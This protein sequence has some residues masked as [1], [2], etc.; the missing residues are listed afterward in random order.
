MRSGALRRGVH[1]YQLRSGFEFDRLRE[2][3]SGRQDRDKEWSYSF[4]T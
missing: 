3:R 2:H 1:H 4:K